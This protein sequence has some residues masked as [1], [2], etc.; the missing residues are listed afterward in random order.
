MYLKTLSDEK[1]HIEHAKK[2][3]DTL[4]WT[5]SSCIKDLKE[6]FKMMG[7][8][9]KKNPLPDFIL[10]YYDYAKNEIPIFVD[11]IKYLNS[12]EFTHL[13]KVVGSPD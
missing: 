11:N 13:D 4:K 8:Y 1:E 6:A 3:Q 10:P 5:Q 2:F 9:V 7:S 12:K